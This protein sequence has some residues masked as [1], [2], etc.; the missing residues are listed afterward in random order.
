MSSLSLSL[1]PGRCPPLF[2][3]ALLSRHEANKRMDTFRF[4]LCCAWP[5]QQARE[6]SVISAATERKGKWFLCHRF[7][8]L[9]CPSFL[10][11]SVDWEVIIQS[12]A[13]TRSALDIF[14][15]TFRWKPAVWKINFHSP[16][17]CFY[18]TTQ[19]WETEC[20]LFSLLFGVPK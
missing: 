10:L 11:T 5:S 16:P 18:S 7:L 4:G 2:P 12:I 6:S 3:S 15:Y 17:P 19:T 1:S 8:P 9:S 20:H 13:A 14:R